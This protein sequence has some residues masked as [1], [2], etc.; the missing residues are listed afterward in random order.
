MRRAWPAFVTALLA[1]V[2]LSPI[3]A[4]GFSDDHRQ[5]VLRPVRA[6]TSPVGPTAVLGTATGAKPASLSSSVAKPV[7]QS[8]PGSKVKPLPPPPPVPAHPVSPP[9]SLGSS[10]VAKTSSNAHMSS[11][12]AGGVHTDAK[13]NADADASKKSKLTAVL[14]MWTGGWIG[15]ADLY[16]HRLTSFTI[17]FAVFVTGL[18]LAALAGCLAGQSTTPERV[19]ELVLAAAPSGPGRPPAP[20]A[21]LKLPVK[22]PG[23]SR[24]WCPCNISTGFGVASYIFTSY[25]SM[26]GFVSVVVALAETAM[27]V[28]G[29]LSPGGGAGW[30]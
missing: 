2:V 18:A 22:L 23:S 6:G 19:S 25:F 5:A 7:N 26:W 10:T 14:L 13:A 27:V 20:P 30:S 8:P 21:V 17:K 16:L 9:S 15:A 4:D 1:V 11:K 29:D 3:V 12:T 28:S 24:R